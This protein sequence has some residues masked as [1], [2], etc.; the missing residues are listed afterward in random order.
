MLGHS[1]IGFVVDE[2]ALGLF[3]LPV[4]LSPPLI[5]IPPTLHTDLQL[6]VAFTRRTNGR[7]LGTFKQNNAL[8]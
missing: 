6:Y 7:S 8:P 4:L 1:I 2:V 3:F 5:V